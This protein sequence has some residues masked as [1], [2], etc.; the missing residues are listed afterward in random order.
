MTQGSPPPTIITE[1]IFHAYAYGVTD[2]HP[3]R[4]QGRET[5]IWLVGWLN[6]TSINQC[7]QLTFLMRLR[8]SKQSHLISF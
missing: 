6:P 4:H 8:S 7:H 5:Q 2:F 1:T 3:H